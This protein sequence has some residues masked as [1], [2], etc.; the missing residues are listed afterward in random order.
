M[1][2]PHTSNDGAHLTHTKGV[3]GA[4]ITEDAFYNMYHISA[5]NS[6]YNP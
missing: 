3:L 5:E 6:Y 4:L 2:A 1:H